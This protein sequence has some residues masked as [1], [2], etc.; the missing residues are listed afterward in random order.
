MICTVIFH[1]DLV[2]LRVP[3]FASFHLTDQVVLI[4]T[5]LFSILGAKFIGNQLPVTTMHLVEFAETLSF[6]LRPFDVRYARLPI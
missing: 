1:E 5:A 3:K 4:R 2:H 6:T